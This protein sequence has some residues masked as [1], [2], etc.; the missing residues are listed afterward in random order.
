MGVEEKWSAKFDTFLRYKFISTDYPLYGITPD[1]GQLDRRVEQRPAHAG[2][3][4]GAGLH[5]DAHRL[6]DGECHALRGK[7]H[8]R[9][10]LRRLDEQQPAVHGQRL[11]GA[12][13]GL[14]VLGRGRRDG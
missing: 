11:V 14:V 12:D 1:A 4:R 10:A 8:E 9:R 3:P 13:A 2:E 6:P 5:L 7:R